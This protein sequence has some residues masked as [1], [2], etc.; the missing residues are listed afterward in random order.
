MHSSQVN[1]FVGAHG[2]NSI[3]H[4]MGYGR[5]CKTVRRSSRFIRSAVEQYEI[6]TIASTYE[7]VMLRVPKV[8]ELLNKDSYTMEHIYP[9]GVY[10][11]P[12]NYKRVPNLIQ[13]FN[14]F[15]GFMFYHGYFP[16]NFTLLGFPENT[17]VLLDFSQFGTVQNGRIKLKH[18]NFPLHIW[19]AE[20]CF[21]LYSF[22][23]NE[24]LSSDT[25]EKIEVCAIEF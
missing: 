23:N 17:F 4:P 6:H 22:I 18:I 16:F 14:R 1:E 12:T 9:G 11:D 15:Y 3:I 13:E 8:Y 20:R 5:V 7:S 25:Q 10:I 2:S 24:E 21:G 19:M